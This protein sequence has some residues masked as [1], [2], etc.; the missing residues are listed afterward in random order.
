[1]RRLA[2]YPPRSGVAGILNTAP[3]LLIA[4][5]DLAVEDHT[6]GWREAPS[7]QRRERSERP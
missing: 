3:V 4:A 1:M 2:P 6:Q 5:D 7:R